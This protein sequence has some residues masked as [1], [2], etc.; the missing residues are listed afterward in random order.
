MLL[1]LTDVVDGRANASESNSVDH[2][3]EHV[4]SST[5]STDASSGDGPFVVVYIIDSFTYGTQAS[6]AEDVVASRLAT[7]GL[8]QCY[9]GMLRAIPDHLHSSIQLQVCAP[10]SICAPR[11]RKCHCFVAVALTEFLLI[12]YFLGNISARSYLNQLICCV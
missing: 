2:D 5:S 12:S 4:D 7:V 9:A 6:D 11:P 1:L 3:R 10:C 8:L